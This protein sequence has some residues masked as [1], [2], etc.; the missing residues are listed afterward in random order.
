MPAESYARASHVVHFCFAAVM[1]AP[2][3][4]A[5][6]GA[7]VLPMSQQHAC[8]A[9]TGADW[10]PI[11]QQQ[12][13][14]VAEQRLPLD[15]MTNGL[16]IKMLATFLFLLLS[17]YGPLD[18][19][20]VF[21]EGQQRPQNPI[22]GGTSTSSTF[23]TG[24]GTVQLWTRWVPWV[25]ELH[26]RWERH[27]ATGTGSVQWA[28]WRSSRGRSAIDPESKG[29]L[30]TALNEMVDFR[31]MHGFHTP[32]GHC[33]HVI[34]ECPTLANSPRIYDRAACSVCYNTHV[35]PLK[36]H[37]H[38]G[39]TLEEDCREFFRRHGGRENYMHTIIHW[40]PGTFHFFFLP[41]L[42]LC[43]LHSMR[44]FNL[45]HVSFTTV[46]WP[47]F[48]LKWEGTN[49]NNTLRVTKDL[50]LLCQETLFAP[51]LVWHL[52]PCF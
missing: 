27:T 11:A 51:N 4:I 47:Q 44:S 16:P 52:L 41:C 42:L 10:L 7:D 49:A 15:G 6:T 12:A 14:D 30:D 1:M 36:R 18:D 45:E 20:L 29:L 19:S 33:W 46:C 8:Y 39:T 48:P 9:S 34:P 23:F 17:V 24:L 26:V 31:E 43:W 3:P 38:T 35:T 21:E 40:E 2:L 32:Y 22:D 37:D 50:V 25:L 5:A 28:T 13:C